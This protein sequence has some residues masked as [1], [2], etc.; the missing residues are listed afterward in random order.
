MTVKHAT[1][2]LGLV[3]RED[4]AEAVLWRQ[5]LEEPGAQTR[6][7]I[8]ERYVG[9]ALKVAREQFHRRPP[10]NFDLA[11]VEQLSIEALLQSIDRYDPLRGVS[12]QSFARPR[13]SGN[14]SNGLSKSSDATAHYS[15]RYRAERERLAS[16]AVDR[17]GEQS[18]IAALSK[19]AA[20]LA[21]GLML[22]EQK[23]VENIASPEPSAYDTLAWTELN[24]VLRE[25]VDLLP[26][27]E[28]FIVKQHYRNGVSFQQIALLLG[29]S[30][31]RISQLHASALG[32]LRIQ[33]SKFR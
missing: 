8:F 26:E 25:K 33:L 4:M 12:F 10:G 6:Q 22:E 28:A 20:T 29:L 3:V 24:D 13:L 23:D 1:R 5:Y 15:F 27:K 30:K 9:F 17:D 14:I 18:A 7:K 21:I 32:R 16:L 2:G 19:L 31:G 11:D